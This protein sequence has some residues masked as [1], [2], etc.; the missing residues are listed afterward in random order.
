ML[1]VMNASLE[2]IYPL[3]GRR[4]QQ[5]RAERQFTQEQLGARLDPPVT[6]ASIANIES[7]KQ[8]LL[9]HTLVQVARLLEVA[10]E[11]LLPGPAVARGADPTG[12]E[13]ELRHKLDL[14]S[15]AA[16]ALARKFEGLPRKR[17]T[18]STPTS[19]PRRRSR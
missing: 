10:V 3:L 8:R 18:R 2:E 4:I 16:K 5:R 19:S 14:P 17:K 1:T 6:R 7:G 11:D 15:R 9:V 13:S 12:I